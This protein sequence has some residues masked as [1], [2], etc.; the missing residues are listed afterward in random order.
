MTN[1]A[2]DSSNNFTRSGTNWRLTLSNAELMQQKLRNR[3]KIVQ[4]EWYLDTLLGLP[5]FSQIFVKNPNWQL[6]TSLI[7]KLILGT[8]GVLQIV[9]FGLT[10]DAAN[11]KLDGSFSVQIE[12]GEIVPVVI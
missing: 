7:K 11:R 5:Y 12:S 2:L 10:I 3:L 6:V 1:L 9:A 8:N 4:G